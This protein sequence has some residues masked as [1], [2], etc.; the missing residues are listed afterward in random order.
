MKSVIV[1]I[2]GASGAA[3]A[4]RLIEVL[5]Q[6]EYQVRFSI[7]PTGCEIF[8]Q[9]LGLT[10]D[11]VHFDL[12]QTPAWKDFGAQLVFCPYNDYNSPI[13]SGSVENGGMVVCPCTGGSLG[14]IANGFNQNVIH[15][16]AEVQLKERRKLILV[17]R[18]TPLSLIHLENMTRVTKAGGIILPACPGFYAPLN[19][20]RRE[21]ERGQDQEPGQNQGRSLPFTIDSIIDFVVNRICQQLDPA[22][23][24]KSQEGEPQFVPIIGN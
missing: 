14:A 11:P 18:E 12:E 23:T 9:E 19:L 21:Q 16:A 6:N 2:T 5:L 22:L 7:T 8:R 3:Y 17:V 15:R 10:I 1:G 4:Y 13:A 20:P 24:V